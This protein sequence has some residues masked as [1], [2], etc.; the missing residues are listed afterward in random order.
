MEPVVDG[1][2]GGPR[3]GQA[4]TAMSRTRWRGWWWRWASA[5]P[6][7]SGWC[8]ARTPGSAALSA[9]S[10]GAGGD[11]VLGVDT[12][13]VAGEGAEQQQEVAVGGDHV[14]GRGHG[15]VVEEHGVCGGVGVAAGRDG[16]VRGR[17]A[18]R[19]GHRRYR[20]THTGWGAGGAG[21]GV[22]SCPEQ[23][24]AVARVW[25]SLPARVGSSCWS[26]RWIGAAWCGVDVARSG[27]CVPGW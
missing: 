11:P 9:S 26:W 23:W 14:V 19:H 16:R 21:T 24:G 22:M 5:C 4:R 20:V 2:D 15:R 1:D 8:R 27:R 18:V 3:R 17:A 13:A 12:G 6:A 10:R 7:R 25:V